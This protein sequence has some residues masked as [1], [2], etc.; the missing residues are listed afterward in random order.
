MILRVALC[1]ALL[2][3]AP[4]M[5]EKLANKLFGAMDYPSGQAAMPVGSYAC[6]LYTSPSPRD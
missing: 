6:L 5:A 2:I 3:P 4:A 1:L